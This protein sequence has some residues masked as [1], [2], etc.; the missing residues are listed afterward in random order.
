MKPPL[1]LYFERGSILSLP[2][3]F[4]LLFIALD[5]DFGDGGAIIL[6]IVLIIAVVSLPGSLVIVAGG[7]LAAF[8]IGNIGIWFFMA[9]SVVNAHVMAMVYARRRSIRRT[10][11]HRYIPKDSSTILGYAS[12]SEFA[13]SHQLEENSVVDKIWAGELSGQ[14]VKGAW[15]VHSDGT[16]P[17]QRD[18]T[19]D[20]KRLHRDLEL[21]RDDDVRPPE[22]GLNLRIRLRR[23][24]TA[25]PQNARPQVTKGDQK[26]QAMNSMGR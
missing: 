7:A 15:Y 13:E 6:L 8:S 25:H 4:S 10:N 23:P 22:A 14:R 16:S 17:H 5:I 18:Q 11:P 26:S 3:V 12:L 1:K 21:R 24:T 2:L 20:D 9:L 19:R